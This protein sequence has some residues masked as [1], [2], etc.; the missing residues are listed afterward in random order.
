M[1]YDD[2]YDPDADFD[3]W[4]TVG[5]GRAIAPWLKPGDEVLEL[6]CATGLMTV[7]LAEAGAVVV[8]VDRSEVYLERA[9]A[10][11][12]P[13]ASFLAHDVTTL[14]LRRTFD[15]V[16]LANVA[17]E[18]PDPAALFRVVRHHLRSG[19]LAHVTVPNP[20][21]LHRLLGVE[22]G[23]LADVGVVGERAASLE[24]LRTVDA[25][26]LEQLAADVGL[27]TVHRAGVMLKPLPNAQMEDL[28][29]EVMEGFLAVARQLPELC[30]MSYVVLR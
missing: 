6:G 1:G 5:T 21:S 13:Q 14:D 3:R 8:G 24:T 7:T 25:E 11:A 12:L 4:F 18:V 19:G 27:Q 2:R 30:A 10:R 9:R 20:R 17:H 29:E 22:M 28:P 23:L 26:R 15:H 16:V